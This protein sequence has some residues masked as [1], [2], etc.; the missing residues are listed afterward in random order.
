[1]VLNDPKGA[2]K[3]LRGLLILRAKKPFD[4]DEIAETDPEG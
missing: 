1:M 4:D 3:M 2:Y